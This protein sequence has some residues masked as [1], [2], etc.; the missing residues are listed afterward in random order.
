M[1]DHI[2]SESEI[3]LYN[4]LIELFKNE[5]VLIRKVNKNVKDDRAFF[6]PR[7]KNYYIQKN[8]IYLILKLFFISIQLSFKNKLNFLYLALK[9]IDDCLYY[10]TLFKKIK[11]QN[12]IMHQHYYSNNIKNYFFKKN[13]GKKSCLIQKNINTKIQMVFFIIAI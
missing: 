12:I 6:Y 10:K 11:T 4:K 8:D 7:I 9:L 1:I 13:G 2:E 5:N 3:R